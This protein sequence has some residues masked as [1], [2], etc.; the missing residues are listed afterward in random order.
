MVHLLDAVVDV[1]V[2]A[3]FRQILRLEVCTVI[4]V[5]YLVRLLLNDGVYELNG[6]EGCAENC[7]S[8][9]GTLSSLGRLFVNFWIVNSLFH[10]ARTSG[11]SVS[12]PM[13]IEICLTCF[14]FKILEPCPVGS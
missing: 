12:S 10:Y 3:N 9:S 1:A 6:S 2:E 5:L 14:H 13:L 7:S 8:L 4:M 11:S